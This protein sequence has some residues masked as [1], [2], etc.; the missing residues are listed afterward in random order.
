MSHRL[1]LFYHLG[2]QFSAFKESLGKTDHFP[3]KKKKEKK[4]DQ[5]V[6]T[7]LYQ[8]S[9]V[10][11]QKSGRWWLCGNICRIPASLESVSTTSSKGATIVSSLV[12]FIVAVLEGPFAL[13]SC[14]KLI[15]GISARKCLHHHY[16][17]HHHPSLNREGRW[18]IADDFTTSFQITRKILR[19]L[20]GIF[21]YLY[22]CS[23]LLLFSL[24]ALVLGWNVLTSCH[25]VMSRRSLMNFLDSETRVWPKPATG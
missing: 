24:L 15:A 12:V 2:S 22:F 13:A 7:F 11:I 10:K 6:H 14:S 1:W 19:T 16:H 21:S 25:V 23:V 18:G 5:R 8:S 4:R 9:L 20:L 3:K 17:H